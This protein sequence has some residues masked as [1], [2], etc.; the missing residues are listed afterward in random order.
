MNEPRYEKLPDYMI[1][2][3][4]VALNPADRRW[5]PLMRGKYTKYLFPH[6]DA[7]EDFMNELKRTQPH[8]ELRVVP[9]EGWA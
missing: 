1:Q 3:K 8:L 2:L 4:S 5:V 6:Y 7:A 9:A